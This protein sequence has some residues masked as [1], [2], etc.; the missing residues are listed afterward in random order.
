LSREWQREIE[1]EIGE[2]APIE[3][4]EED[5]AKIVNILRE[6]RDMGGSR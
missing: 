2:E 5:Q 6:P 1:E 4:A 3:P